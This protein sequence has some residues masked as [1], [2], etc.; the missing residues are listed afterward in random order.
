M[1]GVGSAGL[2]VDPSGRTAVS[3]PF[4]GTDSYNGMKLTNFAGAS[5]ATAAD[6]VEGV[7]AALSGDMSA[8]TKALPSALK[9]PATLWAGGDWNVRDNRG[10]LLLET[11]IFERATMS[12]GLQ[13]SRVT[14]ARDTGEV[15]RKANDRAAREKAKLVD[16]IASLVRKGD[17]D[18]AQQAIVELRLE[19]PDLDIQELLRSIANRVAAQTL[20]YD[21]RRD[22]NPGASLTGV[23][24]TVPPTEVRRREIDKEVFRAFGVPLRN[25]FRQDYEAE[26]VDALMSD[27]PFLSR[28][29]ALDQL[30]GTSQVRRRRSELAL[31]EYLR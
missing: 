13:S 21:S 2:P 27:N 25:N 18:S 14:A 23:G 1:R 7:V 5:A 15:V 20:P 4:L 6:L 9:R 24:S 3:V 30:R 11:S 19:N 26:Q 29:E 31:P 8:A 22:L 17:I 16:S 10:G 12:L 28:R